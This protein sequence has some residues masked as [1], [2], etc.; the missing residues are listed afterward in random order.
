MNRLLAPY[1][2]TSFDVAE[3][4]LNIAEVSSEDIV[5]DLGCGDGN[6]IIVSAEKFKAFSIGVEINPKL[7]R[8]AW[9]R[10]KNR[11][12]QHLAQIVCADLM[13]FPISKATVITLYLTTKANEILKDKILDECKSGSRI[14]ANMFPIPGLYGEVFDRCYFEKPY[15]IYLYKIK[16]KI[17]VL[18]NEYSKID[19]TTLVVPYFEC[20]QIVVKL[21]VIVN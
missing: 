10:I 9:E 19:F 4:M 12:L 15:I 17:N 14:V 18:D 7:C 6:I 3:D 11:N 8:R 5:F 2:G 13:S 21:N 16:R 20:N 1:V